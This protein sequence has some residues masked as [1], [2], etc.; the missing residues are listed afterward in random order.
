MRR[1][2]KRATPK[3][4]SPDGVALRHLERAGAFRGDAGAALERATAEAVEAIVREDWPEA[5]ERAAGLAA[6]AKQVATVLRCARAAEA[7]AS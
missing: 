1:T 4:L 2:R 5:A 3:P 7:T 6:L